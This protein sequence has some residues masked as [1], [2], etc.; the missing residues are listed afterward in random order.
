[1]V[2]VS[3]SRAILFFCL[4][5][6]AAA[7]PVRA[8]ERVRQVQEELRKRNLYFGNVDGQVSAEL[9]GA[10]KR[11]QTRKGFE[12][13]GTLD[14]ETSASLHVQAA[15]ISKPDRTWPDTLVL[16][17]DTARELPRPQ[18]LALE[19]EAE[20]NPDPSPTLPP[21]AESPSAGQ[22]LTPERV[23]KFVEDYLRD[24]ET[25][26]VSSQVRY[27]AFPVQYFDHGA[28][29]QEFVVKDTG[30]YV[31][32][33]PERKY[34]LAGPVSFFASG[35]EAETIVQFPISFSVRNQKHAVSGQTQN[36]WTIRSEGKDLKIVAI[37]EQRLRE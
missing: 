21:P 9:T 15:A 35:K 17:S 18:R 10:L 28:V 25:Q 5:W 1:M 37:R 14:D 7:M 31:K 11:Y 22:D 32:R 33:W 3:M 36:F 4:V 30:N 26:D 2:A 29:P 19:K 20:L 8:D 13:T 16:R 27:Y 6:I 12:V 24:A 23:K 34:V